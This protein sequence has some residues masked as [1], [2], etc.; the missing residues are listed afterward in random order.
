MTWMSRIR[1]GG[2]PRV[3][4]STSARASSSFEETTPDRAPAAKPPRSPR[5]CIFL[6]LP[7][8]TRFSILGP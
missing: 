4:F 8:K 1:G 3:L 5:L 6:L 2:I 7:I